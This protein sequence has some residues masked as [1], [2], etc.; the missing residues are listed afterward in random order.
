MSQESRIRKD[1]G[2]LNVGKTVHTTDTLTGAGSGKQAISL[3]TTT[4]FLVGTDTA[5][6]VLEKGQTG[7]VKNLLLVSGSAC[8]LDTGDIEGGVI[9]S[10]DL[11]FDTAGDAATLIFN[12]TSW[13]VLND[14]I[15]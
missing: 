4:T 9:P 3:T 5:D 12:G 14:S 11:V 13:M 8:T 15:A 7:Q 1:V 10:S 6:L 2:Q